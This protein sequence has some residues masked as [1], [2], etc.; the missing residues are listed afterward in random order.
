MARLRWA[1]VATVGLGV[2]ALSGCS[3]EP[4][5][6]GEADAS[7]DTA[8]E[9]DADAGA[10]DPD[11]GPDTEAVDARD[12]TD[13]PDTEAPTGP[14]YIGDETRRVVIRTGEGEDLLTLEQDG[15]VLLRLPLDAF[16][17]GVVPAIDDTLNYDPWFFEP[18][19]YLGDLYDPPEGLEWTSPASASADEG[20]GGVVV[21][22]TY[23][24]GAS[25]TLSVT[26]DAPGRFQIDWLA[27]DEGGVPAYYRLGAR[28]SADEGFY[29]LG[30]VFD[31][32]EHRGHARAMHF[33]AAP[34]E[35]ANNEAHVPIPLLIGT[36]GWGLFVES[37]RLGVFAVA[38][39]DDDLV[40]VTYGL[41]G[42]WDEGLRVHLFAAPHPLDVTKLYYDVTG[43]PG[44]IARYALG[45][46]IWRDEVD[47][48]AAVEEDFATIRDLD[49][50]TTG[51]WI[52]RPYASG[53]NSFDFDP[54]KYDD[55]VLM[56][57]AAR[58]HGF[59]MALWHTPYVDPDDPDTV[60]LY[61]YAEDAGYFAPLT[62][63]SAVA[64]W[65]PPLDFTNPEA[66]AWWQQQIQAYKDLGVVGYKLDY[67]EEVIS[68]A[69]GKRIPW[70][71]HDGSDELTMHRGYQY[72]YHQVYAETLPEEGGFLLCRTGM[73]GD[74]TLGTII[75][76]GDI[77]ANFAVH[78]EEVFVDEDT[79]YFAVGGLPAA[80]IAGSSLGPSGYPFFASDTGG[81]RNAPPD[82]ETFMRW[83]QH[84]ALTPVMQVGTNTN[85]LPWEFGPDDVFD[86]EIVD[87]Y[88][89]H[90]RLH[91]RLWPY[92]WT[93]VQALASDGRPI[94][95]ALGLAHPELGLHPDDIYLLGD[96]L[97]VAA[98]VE[99]GVTERPVPLPAGRWTEWWTGETHEGEQT[100]TAP[101][102][103]ERI[104]FFV[105]AGVPIPM[106]RPTIDTLSP[107]AEG[108]GIDTGADELGPLW[109]T[110]SP[111]PAG[112]ITVY[113]GTVLTQTPEDGG[114]YTLSRTQ[115]DE[116]GGAVI[117]E[118]I[119]APEPSGA[120]LDD[121]SLAE[122]S[123][124][125]ARGGTVTVTLPT[126]A[127]SLTVAP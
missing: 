38:T 60:A 111:G 18:D 77:D 29:G 13:V 79:S 40:R 100:V 121:G 109:A 93:Y 117:F 120:T 107:V 75:W 51:Y 28:A 114:G 69:I 74:Q 70:L 6:G 56:M 1:L 84:T 73:Y 54:A 78:G 43:Y 10:G 41:G 106:L 45:P 122:W 23:E 68:G 76:P 55:A 12:A 72:L 90:A 46:W 113:D 4:T 59:E 5:P 127:Q 88:R 71:F 96:H 64:N 15:E 126:T 83:F 22:L 67:G 91:L 118:V 48:Q 49:L 95:R 94:Q 25:G 42:A 85:D 87:A 61:E 17:L 108:S 30:E 53:V 44:A 58:D 27:S 33:E 32:V 8:G 37:L 34:L 119:G 62:G 7:T 20:E 2:W 110:L 3:D 102:P 24:G 115:G 105:R 35:S 123:W 104:P 36:R 21:T 80:V 26:S 86:P 82:K 98:V 116:L 14:W 112:E 101:A 16:A 39:H 99:P 9:A 52:D 124:T 63:A 31:S 11:E 92:L 103:A 66:F 89:E 57:Q 47:G 81:Y 125:P 65:G 97:L 19:V 50:A